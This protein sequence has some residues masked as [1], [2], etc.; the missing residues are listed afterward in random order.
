VL[1][2]WRLYSAQYGPGLDGIGGTFAD[3]RWHRRG[4]R[5]VYFG[6]TAAI[7]VLER[8]AHTDPDLLPSN[9]RLGLF[10]FDSDPDFQTV[11][12]PDG[13][14]QDENLTQRIGSDWLRSATSCLLKVPSVIV[15]EEQNAML[16]ASHPDAKRLQLLSNR[17]FTF[18]LRLI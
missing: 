10:A 5:V 18:D 8:L 4:D 13:W 14:A 16:N 6:L 7:T 1:R 17:P 2:L 11:E 9:L 3:G 12:L 15:P